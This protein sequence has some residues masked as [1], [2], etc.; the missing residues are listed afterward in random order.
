MYYAADGYQLLL[1]ILCAAG[2]LLAFLRR[3]E[4]GVAIRLA[5]F[6]LL[7]FLLIW[8]ARSRYLVNF[9]PLYLLCA[10]APFAPPQAEP[11]DAV[12]NQ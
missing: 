9:L 12:K 1:W 2:G 7:L 8:E 11:E 6:G 3:D 4:R 10:L 5:C